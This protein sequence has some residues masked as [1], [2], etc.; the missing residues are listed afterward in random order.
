MSLSAKPDMKVTATEALD[1][2]G[3]EATPKRRKAGPLIVFGLTLT[4]SALVAW[5]VYGEQILALLHSGGDVPVVRADSGPVKVRPEQPGGMEVPNRDKLVYERLEG[6][7]G[8]SARVE[9][10]LP[11]PEEP[12]P[13]SAIAGAGAATSTGDS[14][15]TETASQP[16]LSDVPDAETVANAE[17]PEQAPP[18]PTSPPETASGD[19]GGPTRLLPKD[20]SGA[21]PAPSPGAA[22]AGKVEQRPVQPQQQAARQPTEPAPAATEPAPKPAKETTA[23]PPTET[24]ATAPS[25]SFQ[26]A[27]RVQL[28]AARSESGAEAEW[29]RIRG[30][31][32]DLLGE[33]ALNVTRVDLGADKGIFYRVRVGPLADEAAAKTLCTR[34]KQ[35]KQGCLVVRPGG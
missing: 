22:P 1:Y 25:A 26:D 30:E 34:L 9:R 20:E 35:R 12:L 3:H 14:N 7:E 8:T 27:Y 11:Q 31:N 5:L 15:S 23:P 29:R 24:A 21:E 2:D 17:P 4:A 13:R 6:G 19:A 18:P 10:L 33:L 28:L 32:S 16:S